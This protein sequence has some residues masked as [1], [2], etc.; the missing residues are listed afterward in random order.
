MASCFRNICT[1]NYQNLTI[2]FQVTVKNVGDVFFETKCKHGGPINTLTCKVYTVAQSS[3][4]PVCMHGMKTNCQ[5]NGSIQSESETT[6]TT[7]AIGIEG[8]SANTC[9]CGIHI[10]GGSIYHMKQKH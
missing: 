1:K 9:M 5:S 4:V 3:P 6:F 10:K 2:C 7:Y 8:A